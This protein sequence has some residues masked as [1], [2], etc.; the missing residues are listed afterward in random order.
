GKTASYHTCPL[1]LHDALPILPDTELTSSTTT[2]IA[3]MPGGMRL[4]RPARSRTA[5]AAAK[6]GSPD[7]IGSL[8]VSP[9]KAANS[10][11]VTAPAGDR[12]S[13]RLNSSHVK[14]SYAV[15]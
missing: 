14:I 1:S 2:V 6:R 5:T 3:R 7:D 11:G 10:A 12:K 8:S 4:D 15:F 9:S 13:T